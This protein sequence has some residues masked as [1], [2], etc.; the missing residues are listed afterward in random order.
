MSDWRYDRSNRHDV[1]A[2]PLVWF[3][4][5][6]SLL[7]HIAALWLLWPNV[8]DLSAAIADK[9]ADAFYRGP[10]AV[11][12]PVALRSLSPQGDRASRTVIVN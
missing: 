6:L 5:A 1:V 8:R 3:A 11:Q 9:G 10:I 7:V 12:G 2:I 4:F